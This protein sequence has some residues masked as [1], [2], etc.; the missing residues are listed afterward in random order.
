MG[1]GCPGRTGQEE[2]GGSDKFRCQEDLGVSE[3]V[4][5]P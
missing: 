2:V 1:L 4:V 5:Y 3:N